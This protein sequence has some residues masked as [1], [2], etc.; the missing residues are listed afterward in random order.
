MNK[1]SNRWNQS[2]NWNPFLAEKLFAQ[3]YRWRKI[4]QNNHLVNPGWVTVDPSNLCNFDCVWCNSKEIRDK[5]KTELSE[6]ILMQLAEF[7][8]KWGIEAVTV[9]GGG[10]PL[11]NPATADLIERLVFSG[12]QVGVITNGSLIDEFIPALAQCVWVSVSIDAGTSK[13]H[14]DLKGTYKP[15]VFNGIL[16]NIYELVTYANVNKTVLSSNLPAYGVTYKYLLY[17]DNIM[18]VLAASCLAKSIGCKNIC[19]RPAVTPFH[20]LGKDE[21]EF[22]EYQI[23]HYEEQMK[24]ARKLDDDAFNVYE[25]TYRTGENFKRDNCFD[26]CWS[27]FMSGTIQPSDKKGAFNFGLCCDRRGDEKLDL[28]H[29]EFDVNEIAEY[30]GCKKHWDIHRSI[31]PKKCCQCTHIAHNQVYEQCI[32]NDCL[33]YRFI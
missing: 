10:E 11:L 12:V 28:L 25:Y 30:W 26:K 32:L 29:D 23:H 33:T 4:G 21:I 17:P 15:E 16:E 8:P 2:K 6:E 14:H 9:A 22:A 5:R 3:I 1:F 19:F 7:L 24:E 31:D 20:R 27:V 18:E 13:M